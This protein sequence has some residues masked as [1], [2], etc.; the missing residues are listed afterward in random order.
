MQRRRKSALIVSV[1]LPVE[2][3]DRMRAE[4]KS[5]NLRS[6]HAPLNQSEFIRRAIER[7]LSH[8]SRSRKSRRKADAVINTATGSD[9]SER[10]ALPAFPMAR[11][12]ELLPCK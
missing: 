9:D 4:I 6:R 3:I 5:Q 11:S 10:A 1:L 8:S 2:L 12:L 7:D